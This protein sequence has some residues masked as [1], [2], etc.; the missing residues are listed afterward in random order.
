M[1]LSTLQVLLIDDDPIYRNLIVEFLCSRH[2]IVYEVSDIEQGLKLCQE[3][4]FDVVLV[5]LSMP[6]MNALQ[7]M[8]TL[9]ELNLS[10][11]RI[12]LSANTMMEFIAKALRLGATDYLVKPEYDFME[13]EYAIKRSL[14]LDFDFFD[15]FFVEHEVSKNALQCHQ[16]IESLSD[17]KATSS[18][19]QSQLFNPPHIIFERASIHHSFFYQQPICPYF[20]DVILFSETQTIFCFAFTPQGEHI[21]FS[22]LFLRTML[23]EQLHCSSLKKQDLLSPLSMVRQIHQQV[24]KAELSTPIHLVY[25]Y[26]NRMDLSVELA[27]VGQ[28]IQFYLR[29]DQDIF[30]LF[31]EGTQ[32]LSQQREEDV[33]VTL[34]SLILSSDQMLSFGIGDKGLPDILRRNNHQG[35][36]LQEQGSPLA[37]VELNPDTSFLA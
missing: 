1:A 31:M 25:G 29:E 34:K 2:A 16:Y 8:Q 15:D 26:F 22:H 30:H 5:D 36:I 13:I 4:D 33:E 9:G 27:Y 7:A 11:P 37:Y 18:Q 17:K 24:L 35:T 21:V 6:K 10:M 28:Q 19:V 23:N 12:V 20:L 14:S 32:P 3:H